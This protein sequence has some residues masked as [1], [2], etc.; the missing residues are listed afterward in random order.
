MDSYD[1]YAERARLMTSVHAKQRRDTKSSAAAADDEPTST[2]GSEVGVAAADE[3]LLPDSKENSAKNVV[4]KVTG[5]KE[6]Q[7]ENKKKGLKRL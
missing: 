4:G 1:D 5:E 7:K 6:K 3:G 2:S